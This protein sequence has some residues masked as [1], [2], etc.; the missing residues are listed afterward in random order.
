MTYGLELD[1]ETRSD[2]D[3]KR[4]GAY[5]YFESPNTDC[6]MI[7]WKIGETKGRW[8]RGQPCPPEIVAHV[9]AGGMVTAHNNAFERLL[10][11]KVLTP[12]YGWPILRLEQCRCTAATAAAM[13][14]PRA[15][16]DLGAA[17]GLQV[18][19]DKE[20]AALI[21][22]FSVPRKPKK[23]ENPNG[24]YWHEPEDY[25]EKFERFHDYCDV[26]VETEAEG[27]RRMVPL[28][29]DEQA[30]WVIDQ[31]INDRGIRIDARSARAAMALAEKAKKLLDR[32]MREI[33]GG[34]VTACSQVSRLLEW[35]Q[36]QGID[37]A[38][39]AKAEVTDLL[40]KTD[41][42]HAVRRALEVRQEAAKTSVAKLKAMLDG[43]N[44]DGRVRGTNIYHGASTGRWVNV[45]VNFA[46]L[47][48]PRKVYEKA[49]LD[50][51]ELFRAFRQADPDWLRFL[52]GDEVGRPLHLVSDAIRSFIWAAPGHDLVQADYT[53]IEGAVTAWLAGEGWKVKALFEIMAD[54]SLPD[55]YRRAAAGIMNMTT[56][57][58][59]KSHPLRQS[60]GKV[61]ELALG[62][63]GGVM[64]FVSMSR[65][66]GVD[67]DPL[68]GPVWEAADEE[69][70]E[71]AVWR[72]EGVLKRGKEGTD[73]LSREAWL[74]CELIKVGWRAN[75]PAT[76]EAWHA[77]EDAARSAIREP[78]TQHT[79]LGGKLTYMVARGFLWLRLP[80]GRCLA[81]ATP[82]LTDQV[83]AK[84][85]LPDGDWSEPEVMDRAVAEARPSL[86]EIQGSTSPRI[87]FLGVDGITKKWVR[88]PLYSG[89]C[90][91]NP[92]QA[93]ARDLLVNGI[94]KAESA[95]YPVIAH[96]YDE[97]LTEVRRGFGSVDE[98][99]KLIC[100]LPEWA[101]GLP[102]MASGWRGKRYRKD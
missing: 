17:L 43:A 75:N 41:L 71:K 96:V 66:Y 37:I 95:G 102:L 100:E 99:E 89:L 31:R 30:L 76:K 57:E 10:W 18:Q 93:I 51:G 74:A 24:L 42:P 92:V 29:A 88:Q 77:L 62:F 79:V 34:A 87:S 1:A 25:P 11:W 7:S 63:G 78:G 35:V 8:R 23:D 69:R 4:C 59:T 98:F 53:S 22:F 82:R 64:A 5:V 81:Y 70:R 15:L 67:L 58:I 14:L 45:R 61:S 72:Y 39:A 2:V 38:S 56:D 83:W 28:S 19:K 86:Y 46:N 47:P 44:A 32:E 97:I 40:D 16:G 91:Q 101:A 3:L 6:L 49:E 52:Y 85:K 20:G 48:R 80:S 54:P 68:F 13:A 21:R 73:V 55:M 12:R 94:R 60:V 90:F 36:A 50:R 84:I 9:E 33:T 27:D 26:D 65:N